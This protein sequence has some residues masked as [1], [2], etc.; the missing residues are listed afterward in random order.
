MELLTFGFNVNI[1]INYHEF[2]SIRHSV[3]ETIHSNSYS[4]Y[5]HLNSFTTISAMTPCKVLR[6]ATLSLLLAA[7]LQVGVYLQCMSG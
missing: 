5:C 4:F 2:D 1:V 3:F 6:R 7:T